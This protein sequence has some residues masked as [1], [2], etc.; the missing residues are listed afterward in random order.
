[1]YPSGIDAHVRGGNAMNGNDGTQIEELRPEVVWNQLSQIPG[2]ALVDVRSRPE[3][4][5]VGV[6]DL[7]EIDRRVVLAEWLGYPDMKINQGFCEEV[8][9]KLNDNVPD[10]LYFLC[11]SGT[12]SRHAAIHFAR[13]AKQAGKQVRCVNVIEGFEGDLDRDGHRGNVN[14]WKRAGLPWRQS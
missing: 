12:R 6:T 5:F 4:A 13:E 8:R 11:R 3:W 2:A 10:D 14:G 1:M 7:T 9:A